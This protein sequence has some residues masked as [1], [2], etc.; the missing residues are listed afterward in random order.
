[1]EP[2]PQ[3]GQLGQVVVPRRLE[4]MADTLRRYLRRGARANIAKLLAKL[5]PGDVAVLL[6]GLEPGERHETF[7]ILVGDFADVAGEVL[8]ELEPPQRLALLERLTAEE[9]A[10]LLEPLA[11]DDAV[12]LVESLPAE[13]HEKV[14]EIV[15]LRNLPGVQDQLS[16]RGDSA[17]RIMDPDFF[18]LPEKSTVRQAVAAI[19][20]ARDVEMIFY[21]YVVDEDGRLVGVTSLRQLLLTPPD[22]TLREIMNRSVIKV[23]TETDQEE[24][25]QLAARYDLL[26][27]PVT[28]E[29]SKLQGIVT[30]DDI[31]DVVKEEAT[32]D[33]Y[34][35]VGTSDDELLYQERSLKV[36]R[37]RMP[38]VLLN[39]GGLL[40]AGLLLRHFQVSLEEA[41]FLLTFVPVVMGMGGNV[42][43]QAATIAVR[44][45][46][47]GRIGGDAGGAGRLLWQQLKVGAL[48]GVACS[49][50]VAAAAFLLEQ[51]PWYALVVGVALFLAATVAAFNGVAIPVLFKRLGIDPAVASAPLVTTSNDITGILIFFGLASLLIDLLVR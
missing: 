16:Y 10:A 42:G 34:K 38:W 18:A 40:V 7:Q 49:L 22:K 15:D 9:I 21:L 50:V 33:F 28:D 32:E 46:A 5:R 17:G 44:G 3:A 39:V 47:T 31:I 37:I 25:A 1:M 20:E 13:L 4:A 2:L 12:F 24:V 23:S 30:V 35:L 8:T 14:L 29:H 36:A 26:A 6:R 27:I 51:N 48:I 45:L 11:V 43:S 19:Q 41:L